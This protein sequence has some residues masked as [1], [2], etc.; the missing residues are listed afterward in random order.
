MKNE[1][2]FIKSDPI[3]WLL[4]D[5]NP[6]VRYGTLT[7]I[8]GKTE[9][10]K[11]VRQARES[12]MEIGVV[13]AV[14]SRQ[15]PEGCWEDAR[16]FYRSKY[17][18]TVWQL[19]ILA[20][21]AASAKND[22]IKLACEFILNCSQVRATG[23]FAY[24]T[25]EHTG[26]GRATDVIPCL[27]GNMVWSMQRL[28]CGDDPRVQRGAE[29]LARYLRFDDGES[30][31]PSDWPYNRFEMCYGRHS[32]FMGVVKGL[33]AL[34]EIPESKRSQGMKH[35]IEQAVEFLL[36]HHVFKCSHDLRKTAKPGWKRLGFPKMY[37]TDILEILLILTKLGI[38]DKRMQQAV[39]FVES[40]QDDL[41]RW[42]L[43]DTFNGRFQVNIESKGDPSKWVTMSALTVLKRYYDH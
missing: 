42:R 5:D 29:W 9:R 12:I 17:K 1:K 19:I 37:H 31:P 4:E 8:L 11:A 15:K 20:E 6:S 14:L 35:C 16:S 28:G 21:H 39:D 43:Q 25:A 30:R 3:S 36:K 18:G 26:G 32:C 40:K 27:T 41:G 23:G 33:K 22:R 38:R 24:D 7:Q 34:A 13:P 10:S 2:S